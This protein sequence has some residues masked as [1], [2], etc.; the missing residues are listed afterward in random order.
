MLRHLHSHRRSAQAS[1][2]VVLLA[3]L[4]IGIRLAAGI[5]HA[6]CYVDWEKPNARSFYLHSGG[7]HDRCHHGQVPPDPWAEWGCEASQDEP[8]FTL[9]EIPRLP[10]LVSWFAPLSLFLISCR[11]FSLIA[12]HGRSPP[13]THS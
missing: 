1:R 13:V 4:L 10:P 11:S 9:P 12:A 3:S 2:A 5:I 6:A 7:D 8:G